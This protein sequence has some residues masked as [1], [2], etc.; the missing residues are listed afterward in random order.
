MSVVAFDTLQDSARLWIF[1]AEAPLTD[2]QARQLGDHLTRF[3]P[4]WTSHRREV[5]PGW[6][7]LHGRFLLIG[8]DERTT[9]LSGCS[10]DSLVHSITTFQEGAGVN[11]T[12]TSQY[13]FYRDGEGAV[14]CVSRPDF[15]E[16]VARGEAD[17]TTIVFNNTIETIGA[18][19]QGRWEGPMKD[20]WHMQAFGAAAV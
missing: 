7:L 10:I 5:T 8:V 18:F 20:S 16:I 17:A 15:K 9:D 3:L 11:L 2:D 19:R 1:A 6:G 13:V 4:E 12:R 14:R